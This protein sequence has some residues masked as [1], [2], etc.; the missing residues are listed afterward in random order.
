MSEPLRVDIERFL[1]RPP[2]DDISLCVL[3]RRDRFLGRRLGPSSKYPSYRSRLFRRTRHRHDESRTVHEGIRPDGRVWA[4]RGDLDHELASSMAEAVADLW[5]YAALDAAQTEPP[6]SVAGYVHALLARPLAKVAFRVVVDGGWRDGWRGVLRLGLDVAADV[7]VSCVPPG[8]RPRPALGSG[9]RPSARRIDRVGEVR[10]VAVDRGCD[11]VPFLRSA[12]SAGADVAIVTDTALDGGDWLHVERVPRFGPL[13]VARAL[14]A[15]GQMRPIDQLVS[16][17][18]RL[19]SLLL[20]PYARGVA[21]PCR[22][23][24]VDPAA[25]VDALQ[26][27]TR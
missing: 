4:M 11:A 15:I 27:C 19:P 10:V 21:A 14:N 23:R 22:W 13:H 3:P 20:L 9:G 26:R 7:V 5:R 24:E 2:S 12:R 17:G 6:R 1:S 25:L 8:R 18:V 16:G